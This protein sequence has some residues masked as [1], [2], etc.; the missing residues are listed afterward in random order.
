MHTVLVSILTA[1]AGFPLGTVSG[2][3]QVS[4]TLAVPDPLATPFSPVVAASAPYSATFSNVPAGDYVVSAQT[5]DD[6]GVA[7]GSPVTATVKVAAD[8]VNL[9]VP[10]SLTVTVS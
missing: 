7:L 5:I 6:K 1:L 2:G 10:A 9:D 4:L 8:V 3:I